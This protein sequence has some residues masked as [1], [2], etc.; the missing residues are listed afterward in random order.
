[1]ESAA[2]DEVLKLIEKLKINKIQVL[3]KSGRVLISAVSGE[4]ISNDSIREIERY[5]RKILGTDG[6]ELSIRFE[7]GLELDEI[8]EEYWNEIIKAVSCH[9][10]SAVGILSGSSWSL[11]KSVLA[12]TLA[13]GG[14][15]VLESNGCGR[16]LEKLIA[17]FFGSKVRVLFN[18]PEQNEE[19]WHE[20]I[21][22]KETQEKKVINE[23]VTAFKQAPERKDE[24]TG[25]IVLKGRDIKSDPVP[26]KSISI[27]SQ[28]VT[29]EGDVFSSEC[30]ETRKKAIMC[31]LFVTDYTSSL[32]VKCFLTKSD[33]EK[34]KDHICEGNTLKIRGEIQ[35][36]GYARDI[37]LIAKD[38][39]KV[40]K[41]KKTDNAPVPRVEL[42]MHTRMSAMDAVTDVAE[43]VK[44][45]A[46]WGH[47][48]IA[49]T[50]HGVVQAFP[51][52][53]SAA[54]KYGIKIIY[55][56]EC[57]LLEGETVYHAI[58]LA[59]NR[60]GL[61]NLYK[62]VSDS[63]LRYFHKKPRVPRE[64]LANLREGLLLGTACE[65]GEL[66]TAVLENR[67]ADELEKIA[68]FYDFLEIQPLGNN[69]FLIA[70]GRVGD[71]EALQE[72]N[73][74]IVNLGEKLNIPVV[75]TC[76]VHFMNPEDEV[77]RRILMAGQ[78][79][80]DAD[81]Q[82]PLYLRTTEEMLREFE[83]LGEEKA[84]EVV[85]RNTNAIFD[86]IEEFPPV[87]EG[88]F[89][90]VIDGSDQ[91]I[92][93]LS[94]GRAREIYGDPLPVIVQDRL[95]KELD[96][97]IKNNFSVMYVI[98]WKLVSKSLADG[99]LVGSR[100][101]VGSSFV[102]NM[103]GITE[104]NSLPAHYI[105]RNCKYSEFITDGSYGCGF[106][107]PDKACP[108][109]GTQLDKDGYDIP[110]ETFLGFDGDKEPDIDLNFSGEYQPAAHKYTEELFEEGHVFRAGT[111]STIASKTA[112]GFVRGYL[113]ERGLS[114]TNAEIERLV[115]GCSGIKRTT[116]QH[117]G[118]IIIVPRDKE[119]FD[120]CPIQR[121]ADD[122][123]SDII[124]THFDYNAISGKLLKLDLLGHDDPTVI[125]MLEDLTGVDA[126]SI[127]LADKTT[128]RIFSSTEPLGIKP[129]DIDSEVGTL[130][131]PEFGTG[132]VRQ[133]LVETKP[134]RFSE[135]IRISGLSHGTGVWLNNAQDII[136]SGTA[137]LSEV[138][139]TR[140]D[141]ML[142]L[143]Q[144][145]LPPAMSFKI[146]EDLRKGKGLKEEY[147][148]AMR[149]KEVP[150][151]YI[152]SCKILQYLFPKAHAAAYVM[153]AFRIAWFKVYY[154]EA[155]YAA[156]FTVRAD[157]FDA[158]LMAQGQGKVQNRINELKDRKGVD[159]GAVTQKD[160][161]V[162]TI[163][164]V[165]NEMY[166]RGIKF[167]PV[168]LYKS[169]PVKFLITTGGIR[170]PLNSLQGLGLAAA[171]AISKAREEGEF[172]SVED[173]RIRAGIS[174][175]VIEILGE[176]GCLE[177][178]P[179]SNQLTLF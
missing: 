128:M 8:L 171:S 108:R 62:I 174:K 102:A 157:D 173:L 112:Y 35:Y 87:P 25:A 73:R 66:F 30:R 122:T 26:M 36:D 79:Y 32:T 39:V 147:E 100:G 127:P 125:K 109:C 74:R 38:I 155:F 50:D 93:Q 106:D 175:A 22:F 137:T 130:G 115:R 142:Y 158:G 34:I 167:L 10:P 96:S 28:K 60:T 82:A 92:R 77:F 16:Q 29:I 136:R 107:L 146:M 123:D 138:I 59:K 162:L 6:V 41:K 78:G 84:Y 163:L 86:M 153:M 90:P 12:V 103:A 69:R 2:G 117:P 65:S 151:W 178:L 83:Y 57:Y 14:V 61:K 33:F 43:L 177:G 94:E 131:I 17:E 20:Y 150:D 51:D 48:A 124:T 67:S 58:I 160:K 46:E 159:N 13:N 132:F 161:N 54:K 165:V 21:E 27:D 75:A 18:S 76:D 53:Y 71:T 5:Y 70:S 45:A 135:L 148:K 121:P 7:T 141:I 15:S 85:V 118:G 88:T 176:N 119:I 170:P 152:K 156:Y 172:L 56:M 139:C 168:D 3:K 81:R 101:S 55:G 23:S 143:L 95:R 80:E 89:P 37:V 113:D 49:V 72:L 19:G 9:N 133:M 105:C 11:D 99:Y 164:E 42:H 140:D 44:T 110:F 114:V 91:L 24:D 47:K 126:K 169:D 154:P 40:R 98:A 179:E 166:A 104:V 52:A 68:G 1:V 129:E 116:G 120:F 144:K 97:I 145:G 31:T 4:L 149:E 111:I 64:L 63:H 134:T